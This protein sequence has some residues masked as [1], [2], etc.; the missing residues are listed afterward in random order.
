VAAPSRGTALFY[1]RQSASE[2]DNGGEYLR[3]TTK[4]ND[5]E[6]NE[7]NQ[8]KHGDVYDCKVVVVGRCQVVVERKQVVT[9]ASC[10][11]G[12]L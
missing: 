4:A 10:D 2:W 3:A 1:Q 6:E 9:K 7:T 8:A 12:K 5:Q 11:E